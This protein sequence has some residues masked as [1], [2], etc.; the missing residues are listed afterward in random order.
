MMS[1]P[2]EGAVVG[3]VVGAERGDA[4]EDDPLVGGVRSMRSAQKNP[5]FRAETAGVSPRM[6]RWASMS[7]MRV[8]RKPM[9]LT[10]QS[11]AAESRMVSLLWSCDRETVRIKRF[12]PISSTRTIRRGSW[13]D[14]RRGEREEAVARRSGRGA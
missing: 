3:G 12:H 9:R 5:R 14:D 4:L 1:D 2:G 6:S 13:A 7:G 11:P 10:E 8:P